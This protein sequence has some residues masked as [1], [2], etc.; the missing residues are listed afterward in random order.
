MTKR[1]DYTI[2]GAGAVGSVFGGL[3]AN[4]GFSVQLVNRSPETAAA[5]ANKGLRLELDQGLVTC[6]PDAAQP[7]LAKPA[8][9]VLIFT[10]TH[11]TRAALAGI[12]HATGPETVFASLQ[13]GLGNGRL[14]ADL[15]DS[16]NVC[17]GVTMLPA[18]LLEPGQVRSHG[19]HQS[20]LGPF[21]SQPDDIT[22][23]IVADIRK[24]GIDILA[25]KNPAVPIWQKACFNVALN[26]VCALT[27][28][29]PGLVH[30]TPGLQDQAHLLA[31]EA[32]AVGRAQ[33]ADI[34]AD[35]VHALI[36]KACAGHTYH[37]P[38]MV[39]DIE[40]GRITEIDSLNGF[41]A[42]RAAMHGI[43]VPLNQLITALVTARQSAPVFWKGAPKT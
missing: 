3:L 15:T 30:A 16:K 14:V 18:T 33:G 35:A 26:G 37:K 41:V 20:W 38:S 39:Q 42:G 36:D 9:V 5:I 6:H 17:E 22:G 1:Y 2:L 12:Q 13:N 24:A 43:D 21:G 32:I 29:S 40:A 4:A 8:N 23:G 25:M 34:N 19:S 27:L 10:K 31:D 7:A 28:G 11:Q